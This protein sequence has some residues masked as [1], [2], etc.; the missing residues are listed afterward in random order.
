MSWG[1]IGCGWN[2]G[3]RPSQ[4]E[5][6]VEARGAGLTPREQPTAGLSPSGA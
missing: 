4:G 6:S 3:S 1:K 5:A 2:R